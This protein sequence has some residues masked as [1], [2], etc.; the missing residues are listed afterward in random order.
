MNTYKQ[1]LT[2]LTF[3]TVISVF[4][5]ALTNYFV[6]PANIYHNNVETSSSPSRFADELLKS[7]RGLLWPNDSWNERDI[8][9]FIAQKHFDVDCAILGSSH[10]MQISSFRKN[11]SLIHMCKSLINLSVSGGSLEDDLSLVY[12]ILKSR[13]FPKYVVI[14]IDPW[15]LDFNRDTR[16][17]RY[18]KSFDSM[19]KML[20]PSYEDNHDASLSKWRYIHN[21]VNPS[22]LARS[23]E[24][25]GRNDFEI[26]NVAPFNHNLGADFPVLLPDGSLI[27]SSKHITKS[28]MTKVPIGGTNYYIKHG[29][30]HSEVAI[31][32]FSQLVKKI[33]DYNI[34][35]ILIM[36]PYH[37][38]V[39][40][41]EESETT[42]ALIEMESRVRELGNELSI[43][44]LGSYNPQVIGCSS[45]EF[46]DHMHAKD[47]CLSKITN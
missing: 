34:T 9:K 3:F 39:W 4:V 27:Y 12:E 30:Q 10:V 2:L 29:Q 18:K 42:K 28:K 14:G 25:F 19:K 20:T 35:T 37:P 26:S 32:L 46:Y 8:K 11:A 22:Y 31:E 45:E 23:L 47:S 13:N 38:N 15:T 1:Y 41:S 17:E 43:R 36:T 40:A 44:V 6:D 24:Q 21:L 16:W 33:N 5:I 7:K